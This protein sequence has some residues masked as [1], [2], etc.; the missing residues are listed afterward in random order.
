PASFLLVAA[1]NP[2]PCGFL[3]DKKRQCT[4]S[5][6][7]VAQY[8]QKLSGPLLDRID[9]QINLPAVEYDTITS[10]KS[11]KSI[12]SQELYTKIA[13]ALKRQRVRFASQETMWNALMSPDLIEQHCVC[14]PQAE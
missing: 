3:G 14:S 4:C 7:Q 5:S 2:C 12:S 11:G 8:I 1:L 6:Q 10:E 9:L 13:I